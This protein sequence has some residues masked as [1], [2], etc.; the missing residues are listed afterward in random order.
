MRNKP[1][2]A[3]SFHNTDIKVDRRKDMKRS[4]CCVATYGVIFNHGRRAAWLRI[5][6]SLLSRVK[7]KEKEKTGRGRGKKKMEKAKGNKETGNPRSS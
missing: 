1:A 2:L 6:L 3:G 5:L 4:P 7:E